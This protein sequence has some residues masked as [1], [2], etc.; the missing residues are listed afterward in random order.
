MPC[1]GTAAALD[2]TGQTEDRTLASDVLGFLNRHPEMNATPKIFAL[3]HERNLAA[4]RT[5]LK[6]P[7]IEP[8]RVSANEGISL[9]AINFIGLWPKSAQRETV[10]LRQ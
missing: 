1:A 10:C 6:P 9:A 2:A 5:K 7:V 3:H 8:P 4:A